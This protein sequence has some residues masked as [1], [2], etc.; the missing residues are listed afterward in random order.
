MAGCG[1]GS[2]APEGEVKSAAASASA[3]CAFESTK[4]GSS[5]PVKAV[6]S[7]TP[8]AKEFLATCINPY[9]KRYV[10][11]AEA[12]KEG[13][14]KFAYYSCTQCHGANA[15]GQT[16]V[17]II[18]ERW[19]YAKHDTDKGMFETIAGGTNMGMMAWHKQVTGNPEMLPTDDI[20]KI[21]G[22]LRASYQGGGATPWLD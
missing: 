11:D 9:T 7:D 10:A 16:A 17:S 5:L 18:D 22:W 2:D 8:E 15:G 21:I 1:Q 12:A 14:K 4:D 19:Q 6:E 20:L 13:R 3:Q